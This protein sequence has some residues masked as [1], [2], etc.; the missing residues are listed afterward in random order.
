MNV[1]LICADHYRPLLEDILETRG[2]TLS[3]AATLFL[4]DH[5]HPIPEHGVSIVFNQ[6]DMSQLLTLLDTIALEHSEKKKP[7]EA[8]TGH[9]LGQKHDRFELIGYQ[10]II[11]LTTDKGDVYLRTHK[12]KDYR[13]KEKLYELETS[14][15]SE[16]F[17]RIN[18]STIVN[19]LHIHE[20]IPWFNGRLLL[21]L[22]NKEEVE[23]SRSY[24]NDFKTYLGL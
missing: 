3:P 16:G 2:F 19:V 10:E 23:V 20:I 21:K 15:Q 14:L 6:K 5:K 9:L 18:K 7:K 24:A 1:C 22:T 17:I 4:V 8:L 13:L 12:S 11:F